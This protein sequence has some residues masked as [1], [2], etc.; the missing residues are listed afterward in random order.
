MAERLGCA[1][2]SREAGEDPAGTASVV[3]R[4]LLIEQPGPWGS[5]ALTQ[6]RLP[7]ELGAQITDAAAAVGARPLLIRRHGRDSGTST[8]PRTV[9][10]AVSTAG[11]RWIEHFSVSDPA[12]VLDLDLSPIAEGRSVGGQRVDDPLFLV[13][14]NGRHD[15]CCAELGRPLAAT[16]A[17]VEPEATWEC[18]HFGG[19]RFAG[20]LVCLPHGLYYGRVTPVMAG[21]ITAAYRAGRMNLAH[22]RGRSNYPFPVQAAEIALRRAV[23]NDVIDDLV[24]ESRRDHDSTVQATFRDRVG[25]RHVVEVDVQRDSPP[26]VL[27]C[28]AAPLPAPRYEIRIVTP[29]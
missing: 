17:A 9:F 5:D 23:G 14:T 28:G 7:S 12:E 21:P 16:L 18:S 2:L 8:A 22:V 26:R 29:R 25:D 15:P 10:A 19:D 24:C 13:C 4:W 20:N 6:S 11:T 27:S 3:R 1:A